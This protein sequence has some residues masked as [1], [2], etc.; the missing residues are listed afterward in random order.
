MMNR[1]G[2]LRGNSGVIFYEIGSDYI[3][4]KFSRTFSSYTY[5]YRSAGKNNI[6]QMKRLAQRGS[7]LNGYIKRYV[8]NLYDK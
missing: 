7:G 4:V 3:K 8:N 2:N 5:S 6:E 1:Y